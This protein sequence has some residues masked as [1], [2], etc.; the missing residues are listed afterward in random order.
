MHIIAKTTFLVTLILLLTA[1]TGAASNDWENPDVIGKNKEA[2]H[3]TLM[4]YPDAASASRGEREQSP[5]FHSLNGD[6]QFHWV[7][8]P[9]ERPADF[10]RPDFDVSQWKDD[11]GAVQLA[12]PGIRR[13]AS[14]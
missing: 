8:T 14:T 1:A 2:P 9:E 7:P 10:Y 3:A 11:P 5:Y 12:D 4:V 13:A 6:W